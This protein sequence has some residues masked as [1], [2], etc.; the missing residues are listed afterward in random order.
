MKFP[1]TIRG[2]IES[3]LSLVIRLHR[4][5]YIPNSIKVALRIG[6]CALGSYCLAVTQAKHCIVFVCPNAQRPIAI[7]HAIAKATFI[8][9]DI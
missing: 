9:L 1:E 2:F 3:A 6:N 5:V 4:V 7:D 8:E